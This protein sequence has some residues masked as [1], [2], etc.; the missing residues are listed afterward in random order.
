MK[1]KEAPN[2]AE[3]KRA[4]TPGWRYVPANET[5]VRK[6]WAR[7]GWMPLPALRRTP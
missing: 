3:L 6:T 2:P 1:T 7:F 4:L 5:D